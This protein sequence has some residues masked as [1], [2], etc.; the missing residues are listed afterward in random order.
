MKKRLLASVMIVIG[1]LGLPTFTYAHTMPFSETNLRLDKGQNLYAE[2]KVKDPMQKAVG[3][4]G[5][6]YKRAYFDLGFASRVTYSYEGL[7]FSALKRDDLTEQDWPITAYD[8]TTSDV[9]TPSFFYCGSPYANVVKKYGP[10]AQTSNAKDEY[11]YD[12]PG[13]SFTFT[14]DNQGIIRKISLRTEI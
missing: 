6:N 8:I 13:R 14:V 5:D 12:F 2:L 7:D 3:I 1:V 9:H 11:Y 10:G 4:F